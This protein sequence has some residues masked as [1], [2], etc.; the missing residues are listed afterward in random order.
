MGEHIWLPNY[1][2]TRDC[3]DSC[4]NE[5]GGAWNFVDNVAACT[6]NQ[7]SQPECFGGA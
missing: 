7:N 2:R 6:S 1:E 4:S 3:N 5:L